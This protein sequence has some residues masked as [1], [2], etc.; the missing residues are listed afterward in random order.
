MLQLAET[1]ERLAN[2]LELIVENQKRR[3]VG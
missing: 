2:S 1:Y 3:G